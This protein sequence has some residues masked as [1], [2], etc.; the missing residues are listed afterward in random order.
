M[1]NSPSKDKTKEYLIPSW[2]PEKD[3][4]KNEADEKSS[5]QF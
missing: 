4:S 2:L 3:T 5:M 1:T